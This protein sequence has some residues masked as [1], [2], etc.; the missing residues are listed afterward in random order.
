MSNVLLTDTLLWFM[1]TQ[2]HCNLLVCQIDEFAD[3]SKS[4]YGQTDLKSFYIV[5][6]IMLCL[7]RKE[8]QHWLGCLVLWMKTEKRGLGC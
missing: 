4:K 3:F 7:T 5:G 2:L 1:N 8:A 6:W